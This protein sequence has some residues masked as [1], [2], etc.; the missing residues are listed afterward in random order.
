MF[1]VVNKTKRFDLSRDRDLEEYDAIIN[2]PSCMVIR[3]I[4]EKLTEKEEDGEGNT[5]HFREYLLLIVT[6]QKRTMMV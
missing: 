6:Y 1:D 3:E 5:L 2:D 4:K